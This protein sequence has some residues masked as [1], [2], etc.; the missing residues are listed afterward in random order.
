MNFTHLNHTIPQEL[1]TETHL[2]MRFYRMPSDILVPS[3]TSILGDEFKPGLEQWKQRLGPEKAEQEKQR[4]ADRGDQLHDM[5]E[6]FINNH[7]PKTFEQHYE[8]DN[9][10]LF[11]QIKLLLQSNVDNIRLVERCLYSEN[12]GTVGRSDLIAD[13]NGV[14]SIIDYKSSTHDK[15]QKY[16]YDY[17]LQGTSYATM[18]NEMFNENINQIIIFVASEKGFA[19]K[20][21]KANV[22]EYIKPLKQRI[23][24][25][26]RDHGEQ[27]IEVNS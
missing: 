3:V 15:K 1:K 23:N 18:Y 21:F 12:L 27:I 14:P 11:N 10:K 25:F 24:K 4:C 5:C 26:Y 17:Y 13:Y 22:D 2:G 16:V 19:G 7:D 6:L 9:I 20:T 8:P